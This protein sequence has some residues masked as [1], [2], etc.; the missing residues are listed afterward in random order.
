[1]MD[2]FQL[3]QLQHLAAQQP[4]Q[5]RPAGDAEDHAQR[6]QPH[7]GADL[8]AREQL[9]M[10]FDIDLHHQ[11]CGRYQQHPGNR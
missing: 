7:I 10:V 9:R 8:G 11:H 5:A 4:A 3:A 2:V 6:Q 1:M